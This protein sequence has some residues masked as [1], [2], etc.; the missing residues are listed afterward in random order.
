VTNLGDDEFRDK[1]ERCLSS[2]T[3]LIVEGIDGFDTD[4]VIMS[5]LQK[6][7]VIRSVGK[8][9]NVSDKPHILLGDDK[10]PV[11]YNQNFALYFTGV[12][13][14]PTFSASFYA[15]VNVINFA[16]TLEA[17]ET[18]LMDSLTEKDDPDVETR[19]K[20][21]MA[22][23]T[24]L[25]QELED[26]EDKILYQ[27][28]LAKNDILDEL[29][30]LHQLSELTTQSKDVNTQL[31][32]VGDDIDEANTSRNRYRPV[33]K[34][35]AMLF[36]CLTKLT[37]VN[38]VYCFGLRR[39]MDLFCHN[40]NADVNLPFEERLELM[41][42][43]VHQAVYAAV[44]RGLFSKDHLLFSFLICFTVHSVGSMAEWKLFT[45]LKAP[46]DSTSATLQA[47]V[48]ADACPRWLPS[49]SW[50]ALSLL[51]SLKVF[52]GI[53]A[54]IAA[55]AQVWKEAVNAPSGSAIDLPG[56]QSLSPLQALCVRQCLSPQRLRD[57]LFDYIVHTI[58]HDY[59]APP[60]YD[61]VRSFESS[62]VNTAIIFVTDAHSDPTIEVLEFASDRRIACHVM[63]CPQSPEVGMSAESL[64]LDGID[65][66]F[67]VVLQNCHHG[68]KWLPWL[69]RMLDTMPRHRIHTNFRVWLFTVPTTTLPTSLLANGVKVAYE[70]P[71]NIQASLKLSY[72]SHRHAFDEKRPLPSEWRVIYYVCLLHAALES[73]RKF[74]H[75]GWSKPQFTFGRTDLRVALKHWL[76]FGVQRY[77]ALLLKAAEETDDIVKIKSSAQATR[78][79]ENYINVV[80][81]CIYGG[82]LDQTADRQR[83]RWI[84]QQSFRMG[85]DTEPAAITLPHEGP[86]QKEGLQLSVDILRQFRPRGSRRQYRRQDFAPFANFEIPPGGT[87]FQASAAFSFLGEWLPS[88]HSCDV[89]GIPAS[90]DTIM[91]RAE[92]DALHTS[93][94]LSVEPIQPPTAPTTVTAEIADLV[95]ILRTRIVKQL[96]FEATAIANAHVGHRSHSATMRALISREVLHYNSLLSTIH[97]SMATI[98]D[99][100]RDEADITADVQC[101]VED[102]LA[103]Q[104][105][106]AWAALSF[107]GDGQLEAWVL[108][109]TERIDFITQWVESGGDS[110][111]P[112][113]VWLGGMFTPESLKVALVTEYAAAHGLPPDSPDLRLQCRF[114]LSQSE[115]LEVAAM[116]RPGAAA[117]RGLHLHGARWNA[118]RGTIEDEPGDGGVLGSELPVFLLDVTHD[119]P[120]TDSESF[121]C[122][123][124][125]RVATPGSPPESSVSLAT[126]G[127][128][129]MTLS[130]PTAVNCRHWY[131]R[132]V[133]AALRI[134]T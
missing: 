47:S 37:S 48:S 43:R 76:E 36:F 122:P 4:P 123:V 120:V 5:L 27:L 118:T 65:R 124:Y 7:L 67:W 16:L 58:G 88:L 18:Q 97:K 21:L 78:V 22:K 87:D 6:N 102:L 93:I 91:R 85:L 119:A 53:Q 51:G 115:V 61:L 134:S 79:L 12:E 94:V 103:G 49:E 31:M 23:E 38:P 9:R 105:P 39:F 129:V 19:R 34:R 107:A 121:V 35:V 57:H 55:N 89:Y 13:D 68:S 83:L 114:D 77:G 71:D 63:P 132:G 111:G 44:C 10:D 26:L 42:D 14:N 24:E 28:S 59:V 125:L 33:S 46:P 30:V 15:R 74:G 56:W 81:W 96:P 29:A 133:C 116:G 73:R 17:L 75:L 109:L 131:N 52:Q 130:I 70:P 72:E 11:L 45:Q 117:M 106:A 20:D 86:S 66:G 126:D 82:S 113:C 40:A 112:G 54:D 108:D 100:L 80:T 32:R 62:A 84:V 99:C 127:G 69:S 8:G 1:L 2:G 90:A 41:I 25:H 3:S 98:V 110:M 104:V 92:A 101:I 128:H 95:D 60:A 50:K 64:I